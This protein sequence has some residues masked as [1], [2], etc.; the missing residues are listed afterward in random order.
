[1]K[2][3]SLVPNEKNSV[4]YIECYELPENCYDGE[5]LSYSEIDGKKLKYA[6]ISQTATFNYNG[7]YYGSQIEPSAFDVELGD[8]TLI[9]N[10]GD[11]VYDV[12]NIM[13]YDVLVAGNRI[14][15][16]L[17]I[18]HDKHT[19]GDC[20]RLDDSDENLIIN[21]TING[22]RATAR[23]IMVNDCL[24]FAVGKIGDD[25]KVVTVKVN[26]DS[27][28]GN[29]DSVGSKYITIEGKEYIAS[30]NVKIKPAQRGDSLRAGKNVTAYFDYLGQ[31][32]IIYNNAESE[33][34]YGF[35]L[36]VVESDPGS[37]S[38]IFKLYTL[39]NDFAKLET[40]SSVRI[41]G[42]KFINISDVRD[43]LTGSKLSEFAQYSD[44]LYQ[45]VKYN[46]KDGVL[47]DIW[48]TASNDERAPRLDFD[49]AKRKY[50]NSGE[51]GSKWRDFYASG[52]NLMFIPSP[53]ESGNLDV[54][55]FYV[56]KQ[57]AITN[58]GE[59]YIAGYDCDELRNSPF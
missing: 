10:D 54:D 4:L 34:T 38:M 29:I 51:F 19:T 31:I 28:S 1:M 8:I 37:E 13:D 15:D 33:L 17:K 7:V 11:N 59:Y 26:R 27:V 3:I 42:K 57:D 48:T 36:D 35:V 32:S 30:E 14:F 39:G 58:G 53:D 47:T 49:F 50:K 52:G 9:D 44:K 25:E 41:N 23:D 24:S 56:C 46:I 12:V 6:K 16:N 20:V 22:K 40:D 5:K 2:L 18:I 43:E 55:G 21:V 45:I